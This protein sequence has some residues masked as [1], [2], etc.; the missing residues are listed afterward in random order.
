[1]IEHEALKFYYEVCGSSLTD[2]PIKIND[3]YY[4]I[5][6]K[7]RFVMFHPQSL[8][9]VCHLKAPDRF[10]E[11]KRNGIERVFPDKQ[12]IMLPDRVFISFRMILDDDFKRIVG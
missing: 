7:G 4:S 8:I 3:H 5:W 11:L 9:T 10:H 1:M 6:S 2:A 12:Q